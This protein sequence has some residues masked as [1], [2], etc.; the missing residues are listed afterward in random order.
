MG[1]ISFAA[2]GNVFRIPELRTKLFFTLAMLAI[3]RVGSFITVPGIPRDGL[4]DALNGGIFDFLNLW[5]GGGLG[6]AAIFGLGIM[7]YITASIIMQ[8]MT[9]V[10]PTL[11]QLQ[12]EGETGYNKINRYTRYLAVGLSAMQSFGFYMVLRTQTAGNAPLLSQE[13]ADLTTVHGIARMMLF[14]VSMTAGTTLLMWIGELITQRGIGNGM[15]LLI[16]ASIISGVIPGIQTWMQLPI[17]TRLAVPVLLVAITAAVVFIQEGQRRI[18]VQYAKRMVG[19]K[20]TTGGSTYLPIRVNT[21]GVIPIIFASALMAFPTIIASS[22]PNQGVQ[23]F[24]NTYL[25]PY[26]YVGVTI[27]AGFVILFTFFYTLVQFNPVDQADN[28]KKYGG[29]I[30]GVRPGAPTAQYLNRVLVRL[31]FFGAIYL[32]VLIIL[33]AIFVNVF[34]INQRVSNAFGGTTILIVV[35]VALDTMRQMESQLVMRNYEG[36]LK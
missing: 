22:I 24:I 3:Y 19:R 11:A 17:G 2:L 29:F 15:S 5:T 21:A 27:T 36:F 35:G 26:S 12:K 16:F 33:P 10:V 30:P 25:G 20:M 28:L 9:S 1:T 8:L 31:T 7:P 32:A 34:G 13:Q 6:N 18:P 14:V 4:E 23:D